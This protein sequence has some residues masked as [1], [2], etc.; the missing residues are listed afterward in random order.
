[1][2]PWWWYSTTTINASFFIIYSITIIFFR[3]LIVVVLHVMVVMFTQW[4]VTDGGVKIVQTM[5]Y[6]ML[7]MKNL[8][9]AS[10][11]MQM[12]EETQ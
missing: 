6:V 8:K 2:A 11:F 5:I 3:F 1:M 9:M 7:V 4:L 12:L 10:Y